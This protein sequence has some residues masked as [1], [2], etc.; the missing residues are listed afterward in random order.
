MLENPQGVAMV[1]AMA[2]FVITDAG[3]ISGSF[4]QVKSDFIDLVQDKCEHG[5]GVWVKSASQDM[6]DWM[7]LTNEGTELRRRYPPNFAAMQWP[8][9]DD[10]QTTFVIGRGAP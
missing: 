4:D 10:F 5:G 1:A 2:T 3:I 8:N 7:L 9:L 6:Q